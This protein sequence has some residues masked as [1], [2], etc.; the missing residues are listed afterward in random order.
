[1][2]RP[3]WTAVILI[4]ALGTRAPA[5]PFPARL[6]RSGA[7]AGRRRGRDR[8]SDAA[9][10]HLLGHRLRR[11]GRPDV[12]E[13]RQH[14]LAAHRLAG[15]LH[16]AR[17]DWE[18]GTSIETFDRK[19]GLEPGVV[20]VRPRLA[21]RHA[22]AEGARARPT[23]STADHAWHI[24]GDGAPVAVPPELAELYQLDLW[25]NPP[26]F[27]K[28]ARLPGANPVAFWRWEQIEKGRDGNVVHAREGARRRDHD[29]RQ[30]PRRRH[31]QLAEPDHSASRPR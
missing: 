24:D 12:R 11:R 30:V 31:H 13:R 17:I 9:L 1:M 18:A 5:Q 8:R 19:P 16:A 28:A 22:D 4:S 6:R 29:A 10:R 15:Q 21:G 7:A 26:G 27:L 20:E 14:R 25:L 23:S 3:F 2:R